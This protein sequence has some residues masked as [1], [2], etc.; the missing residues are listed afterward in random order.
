MISFEGLTDQLM[1]HILSSPPLSG[2]LMVACSMHWAGMLSMGAISKPRKMCEDEVFDVQL[3]GHTLLA[4][5]A[6][7]PRQKGQCSMHELGLPCKAS[8]VVSG[9]CA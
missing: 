4:S 2:L 1:Q 5:V 7:S 3:P 8:Y 6:G 9:Q